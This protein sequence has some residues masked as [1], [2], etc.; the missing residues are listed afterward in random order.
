[1]LVRRFSPSCITLKQVKP[2]FSRYAVVSL[3]GCFAEQEQRI[4]PVSNVTRIMIL[5]TRIISPPF[6]GAFEIETALRRVGDKQYA[7]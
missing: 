2:E 3:G 6:P 7:L 4:A 1:M 5:I